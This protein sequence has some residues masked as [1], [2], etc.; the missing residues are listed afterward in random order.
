MSGQARQITAVAISGRALLI[1]GKPGSG[2]SSLALALIDRGAA[3]IGDDGV[4]LEAQG[5]SLIVRPNPNT[6]GLI[7]VRNLGILPLP[8]CSQAAAALVI[9]LAPDA[10]RFIQ[11]PERIA[12][13][14]VTLPLIRF[15]EAGPNL[16]LKA[17]LALDRFGIPD[18][19]APLGDPW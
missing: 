10:P 16:A 15:D 7:E 11:E 9:R 17:E 2:K 5:G 1:D 8:V 12:L 4:V 14:D 18:R 13:L 3:L 6:R 19:P